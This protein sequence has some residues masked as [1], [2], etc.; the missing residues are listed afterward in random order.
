MAKCNQLTLLPFKGLIPWRGGKP[1]T[2]NITVVST[3]AAS[4]LHASSLWADGATELA[5][6]RKKA[7]YSGL[8]RSLLFQPI[9]LEILHGPLDPSALDF[10]G[11][12]GSAAVCSNWRCSWN[13]CLVSEAVG[14]CHPTL[15]LSPHLGVLWWSRPWAGPLAV[16]ELCF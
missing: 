10:L 14:C 6:S 3:H 7:K 2:P 4:Y 12:F 15:Q 11:E 8:P 5:A 16:S 9:A 13:S 1:F